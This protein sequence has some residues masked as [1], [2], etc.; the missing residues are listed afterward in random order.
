MHPER[1]EAALN[2]CK[3]HGVSVLDDQDGSGGGGTSLPLPW[4][5]LGFTV[6]PPKVPSAAGSETKEDS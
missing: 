1:K 2:I 5:S 4:N 3:A 6:I